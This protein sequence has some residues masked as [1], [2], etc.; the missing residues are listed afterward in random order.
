MQNA[1]QRIV[2]AEPGDSAEARRCAV[3]LATLGGA[4]E[5]AAGNAALV[6]TELATN[7]LKHAKH[8]EVLLR[9]VGGTDCAAVEVLAI[10][11]GPGMESVERCLV[12]GYSTAGTPGNGL[13]A[14]RRLSSAFDVYSEPARGTVALAR[15]A[16]GKAQAPQSADAVEI[17]VVCLPVPPETECGDAWQLAR[18]DGQ[19]AAM[20]VDGLGHGVLAAEAAA[21]AV[22]AFAEKP[23]EMP[24]DVLG[25]IHRRMSSTRGG[26]V[27]VARRDAQGGELQYAAI[28]NI[29]GALV[30]NG[31][32]R[33]LFTHNG[34][35]GGPTRPI[36][37]L[38]YPCPA[39]S[40]LIM[41]SDGIKTRWQLSGYP[42]LA[43]RAPGVIAGV[44]YRDFCRRAD[45]ITVLVVAFPT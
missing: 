7:I 9:L 3:R 4:G 17:G 19:V 12:D 5:T 10:D 37:Q 23:F 35:V 13:G 2:I 8:G 34:I 1:Q 44:L 41:H 26:A 39:G 40:L 38:A 20:L 25:R 45:D 18:A 11:G 24:S 14:V 30:H 15:I 16:C 36:K 42:G 31:E 28:G 21:Q 22:G 6:A 29:A 43:Q 32:S 33:G 27:A